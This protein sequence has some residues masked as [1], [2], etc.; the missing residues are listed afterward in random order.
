MSLPHGG[1]SWW[2]A[3]QQQ[4][5]HNGQKEIQTRPQV[6]KSEEAAQLWERSQ[7]PDAPLHCSSPGSSKVGLSLQGWR[8]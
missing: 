2:Q 5:G 3:G 6:R 8:T 1:E 7:P 4:H